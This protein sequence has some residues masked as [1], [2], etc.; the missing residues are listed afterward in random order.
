MLFLQG[1]AEKQLGVV[2]LDAERSSSVTFLFHLR[3]LSFNKTHTF[4]KLQC[5][6]VAEHTSRDSDPKWGENPIAESVASLVDP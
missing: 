3:S 5:V 4:K 6:K 1:P 2:K